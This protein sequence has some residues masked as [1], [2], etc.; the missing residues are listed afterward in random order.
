MPPSAT[1][2]P[3]CRRLSVLTFERYP[4]DPSG[5]AAFEELAAQRVARM[6]EAAGNLWADL[7]RAADDQPSFLL[8]GEWR[9]GAD[10][11]AWHAAEPLDPFDA[12]LRADVTVRRFHSPR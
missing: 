12:V 2:R 9:S 5:L 3:T 10:A 1:S 6:R 11:D 8:L 7:S 4:V